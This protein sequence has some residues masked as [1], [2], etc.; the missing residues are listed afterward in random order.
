MSKGKAQ[1]GDILSFFKR[2]PGPKPSTAEASGKRRRSTLDDD[3]KPVIKTLSNKN[4]GAKSSGGEENPV[5]ISDSDEEEGL[6]IEEPTPSKKP[7]AVDSK[8]KATETH[9]K[10]VNPISG[11]PSAF[12]SFPNFEAPDTWPEIVNTASNP[13]DLDETED[14]AP[15][16]LPPETPPVQSRAGSVVNSTILGVD[17]WNEGDEEGMGMDEGD[18]FQGGEEMDEGDAVSEIMPVDS[19]KAEPVTPGKVAATSCPICGKSMKGKGSAV[20]SCMRSQ[21]DELTCSARSAAC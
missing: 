1:G 21:P 3:V 14:A 13:Y 15:P 4:G 8:P 2:T 6:Q 12:P 20:S 7:K 19:V 10:A 5:V 17:D 11:A 9:K 18:E 16:V